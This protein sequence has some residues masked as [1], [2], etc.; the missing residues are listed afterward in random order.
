MIL[1]LWYISGISLIWFGNYLLKEGY[2]S[3][4]TDWLLKHF[5]ME[6]F[7]AVLGPIILLFMLYALCVLK[8][9][10]LLEYKLRT[11]KSKEDES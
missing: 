10:P 3:E 6:L 4:T 11:V 2:F 5:L 9:G 7:A 8:F 1:T